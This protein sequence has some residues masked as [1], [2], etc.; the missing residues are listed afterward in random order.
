MKNRK[1]LMFETSG[2]KIKR[3]GLLLSVIAIIVTF[4]V[5]FS[6]R[7]GIYEYVYILPFTFAVINT[8]FLIIYNRA[9]IVTIIVIFMEF[10]RYVFTP[11]ILMIERYPKGIYTISLDREKMIYTVFIMVI[12]L[13]VIYYTLYKYRNCSE[14]K[15]KSDEFIKRVNNKM[16]YS[17]LRPFSIV[18]IL[19]T[20]TLFIIF[21]GVRSIYSLI[22]AGELDSLTSNTALAMESLPRGIGWLGNVLGEVTRYIVLEYLLI[23]LFKKNCKKPKMRYFYISMILISVNVL[24]ITSSMIISL[25]GSMVLFVQIYYLY[26]RGRKLLIGLGCSIGSV[27]GIIFILKYLENALTYHSFSQMIQDYTNGFYSIYQAL[28]AYENYNL[29]FVDKYIMLFL[30]DG[31]ANISPLNVFFNVI[32]SSDIYNHYLYGMKFNGGAVLPYVSQWVYY[33]TPIFGPI[34]SIF[35]IMIAKKIE[36]KWINGQG[37]MLVMGMFAIILALTPFMYNFPTLIHIT[38]LTIL[39]LWVASKANEVF[40]IKCN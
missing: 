2:L 29:N 14:I 20:L 21:P 34:F 4:F 6:E 22:G 36:M 13:I 26:P 8:I 35:P 31:I 30:G 25:T 10:I 9:S 24:F 40:I 37:N 27:L 28:C 32:N 16:N 19:L 39:P 23:R 12:E 38:T 15:I 17:I 1:Y 18:I 7:Y 3:V 5:S 11:L 33:F